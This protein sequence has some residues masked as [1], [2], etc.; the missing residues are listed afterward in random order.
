MASLMDFYQAPQGQALP[1]QQADLSLSG[2][3]AR[4]DAGL[5]QSRTLRN[6][7]WAQT[8]L[9]N[10]ESARGTARSGWAGIRSDRVKQQ[11]GDEY[12][13]VQR[14]LDKQLAGLRRAGVLA[15]IGVTI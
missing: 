13:D 11:Y 4:Q 7:G 6:A 12:G 10:S 14:T 1:F 5:A 15:G 3:D 9:V 8:D 2:S